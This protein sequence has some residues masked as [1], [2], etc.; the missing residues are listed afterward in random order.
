MRI[1]LHSHS[2]CS[3]GTDTPT[4]LLRRAARLNIDVLALTDHDTAV[5]WGEAAAEAQRVGI[6]FVRG[7]EISTV[8]RRHSVHL[9]GYGVDPDQPELR[10]TLHRTRE[11]RSDRLAVMLARLAD[12]GMPLAEDDVRRA[13]GAAPALGRPHVADALIEAGY[14]VDRQEAFDRFLGD[15]GPAYVARWSPQLADAIHLV[16]RAGGVAIIA[17]PWGR[18]SKDVLTLPTLT[19]LAALGLDGWEVDHH[20]H[21]E[22]E[23][24]ALGEHADRLHVLATGSSD[25][26]GLGKYNH[27]LGSNTTRVEVWQEI[28]RRLQH[29]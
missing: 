14:V 13:Q 24:A 25:Y 4:A 28:T 23:R 5:G 27:E 16:H 21:D 8:Y 11:G 18:G 12:L 26:H 9:L 29:A 1:D 10:D 19:E 20:D 15:D 22:S 17:H 6:E 3:D 2:S 7:I